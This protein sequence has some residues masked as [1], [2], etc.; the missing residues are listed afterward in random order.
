MDGSRPVRCAH[1]QNN[2]TLAVMATGLLDNGEQRLLCAPARLEEAR[3]ITPGPGPRNR[4]LDL[5]NPNVPAPLAVLVALGLM[6]IRTRPPCSAPAVWA[7]SSSMISRII[8]AI[9][10]RNATACSIANTLLAAS[11]AVKLSRSGH[12]GPVA[13]YATTTDSTICFG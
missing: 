10:S 6:T 4:K 9:D 3:Q 13:S 12:R 5:P 2:D 11:R 8:N 7:I 1:T